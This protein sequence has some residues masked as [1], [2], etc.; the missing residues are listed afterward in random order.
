MTDLYYDGQTLKWPGYG[1]F[2]ASSGL[3]GTQE[4]QY[5]CVPDS[6]PIPE[7]KY[8]LLLDVDRDNAADDGTNSCNLK[9]ARKMQWIPRGA[10]AG[11]C[12]P[13]WANWGTRRVRLEAADSHTRGQ[14]GA[15][16]SGFYL[17][18]STKG[19]SHGCIEV[20]GA[21]FN[22][23][24]GYYSTHLRR[25]GQYLTLTV[26]YVGTSTYGGTKKP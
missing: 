17:H 12:E 5:Q 20:D 9:P 2:N 1:T 15:R 19:Y 13:Y 18:D 24:I 25:K 11:A 10:D 6:G 4:P 3:P 23:Y 8:K 21:F 26:K 16:R 22:V 14:C 7:G